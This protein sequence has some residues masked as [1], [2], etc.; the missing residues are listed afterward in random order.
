MPQVSQRRLH[1]PA[2][3]RGVTHG[4]ETHDWAIN[5]GGFYDGQFSHACSVSFQFTDQRTSQMSFGALVGT[6]IA[7]KILI[8]SG[9]FEDVGVYGGA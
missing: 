8:D 2:S 7:G 5:W 3:F 1:Q 6:P 4:P 9:G